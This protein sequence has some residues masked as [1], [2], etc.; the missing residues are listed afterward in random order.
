MTVMNR[1][2]PTILPLRDDPALAQSVFQI[3][4]TA[5]PDVDRPVSE[6]SLIK[7][8]GEIA[9]ARTLGD[10]GFFGAQHFHWTVSNDIWFGTVIC[11]L[12]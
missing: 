7:A 10:P 6:L 5:E 9:V 2:G 11:W 8:N 12:P 4:S 1:E 3:V